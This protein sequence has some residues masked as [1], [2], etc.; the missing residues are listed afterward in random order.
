MCETD[1]DGWMHCVNHRI[2]RLESHRTGGGA[3]YLFSNGKNHV[4]TAS[5]TE[6]RDELENHYGAECSSV[7]TALGMLRLTQ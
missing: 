6:L 3:C 1:V 7:Q 5:F 2:K 4:Q